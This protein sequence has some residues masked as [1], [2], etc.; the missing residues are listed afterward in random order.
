MRVN[1]I[2]VV[3]ACSLLSSLF[4]ATMQENSTL[5]TSPPPPNTS[6]Q[7]TLVLLSL[8]PYFNSSFIQQPSWIEGPTLFLA[9]QI[10]IDLLNARTDILPGYHLKLI[11]ADTGCNLRTRATLA[12]IERAL[13]NR[14]PVL[15][16]VGPGCSASAFTVGQLTGR[17]ST[18]LLNVHGAGSLELESREIYPN[19][20]STLASTKVF[21]KTLLKLFELRKWKRIAAFYDESR[22]YYSSTVQ[23]LQNELKTSNLTQYEFFA[24][25]VY[26]TYLPL[27]LV[28]NKYRV[29]VLF[30]GP[31]FLSKILCLA[32]HFKM[33]YPVYQFIVVSRVAQEIQRVTF[34]YKSTTF[35]CTDENMQVMIDNILIIHYQ[36][37]PLSHSEPTS[38]GLSYNQFIEMYHDRIE[39]ENRSDIEPSFWSTAFFDATWSLGLVLNSCMAEVNFSSYRY[40][41]QQ[42]IGVFKTKLNSL[43]FEGMSGFISFDK[44]TGYTQRNVDIYRA[45]ERRHM[46]IVA[47]YN[48]LENNITFYNNSG[49]ISGDFEQVEIVLSVSKTLGACALVVSILGLFLVVVLQGLTIYARNYNTVKAISPKLAQLAFAGCYLLIIGSVINII[50]TSWVDS[51]TPEV[52]CYLWNVLNCVSSVGPVLIYGTVCTRTWR[53]YRIFV[54]YNNPGK[55]MSDR[56]LICLAITSVIMCLVVTVIWTA[57]DPFVS[58]VDI[59]G[60]PELKELKDSNNRT[61]NLEVRT[62]IVHSCKQDEEYYAVWILFLVLFNS[63]LMTAAVVLAILTRHIQHKNFKTRQIMTLTYSLSGLLGFGIPVYFILLH[64][65]AAILARFIVSMILFNSYVFLASFLL[66]LPPL[67]PFIHSKIHQQILAKSKTETKNSPQSICVTNIAALSSENKQQKTN[68]HF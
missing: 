63:V 32:Y 41:D 11:R 21:V 24:S 61:V 54:H 57:V 3:V 4:T 58:D 55:F 2:V 13:L 45:N 17:P 49:L 10:A 38:S 8:L 50:T 15:G 29:V 12:I 30:V 67:Y 16:M 18:S 56:A 39:N 9:E 22:L 34:T 31:D 60:T 26:S 43:T 1:M 33:Y 28:R 66:F 19:S 20:Y 65:N 7:Q 37:K 68:K 27:S 5:G 52:N 59:L 36:L 14:E 64:D 23:E 25:A 6:N 44:N 51:I 62:T 46:T 35:V 40:G 42:T 48:A 53:L 47:Y